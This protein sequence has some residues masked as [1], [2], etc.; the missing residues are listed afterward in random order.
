MK[1]II[2]QAKINLIFLVFFIA[3]LNCTTL[4]N[5]INTEPISTTSTTE[6]INVEHID[7]LPHTI[8]IETISSQAIYDGICKAVKI[9]GN[10]F[11]LSSAL[12]LA[13]GLID[14]IDDHDDS[15]NR[16]VAFLFAERAIIAG[17]AFYQSL[18]NIHHEIEN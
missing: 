3:M 8:E 1:K 16:H 6:S 18:L 12:K 7:T 15:L 17:Y 4:L 5:A 14:I 2:I 9:A 11:L 13:E 10:I